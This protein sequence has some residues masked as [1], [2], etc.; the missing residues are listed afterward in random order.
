MLTKEKIL[1]GIKNTKLI[2]LPMYDDEEIGIREINDFEY[3]TFVSEY[4]DVGSFDMISTM[5]G[6]NIEAKEDTT[7]FKTSLKQMDKRKYDAKL[8]LAVKVLDNDLNTET[9]NKK[10]LEQLKP[11]AL[12][13]IINETLKFS[14][15]DSIEELEKAVKSFRK[16]E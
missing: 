7:K 4:N 1:G 14:G 9:F 3:N 13:L 15:L 5:K 11:G 8:N 12:N 2:K 16:E 6:E 10:D